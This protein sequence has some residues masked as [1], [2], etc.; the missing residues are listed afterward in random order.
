MY[1]FCQA[2]RRAVLQVTLTPLRILKFGFH[3]GL[4]DRNRTTLGVE[5]LSLRYI[6]AYGCASAQMAKV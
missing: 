6:F 2:A 4:G 5:W 3:F 1:G